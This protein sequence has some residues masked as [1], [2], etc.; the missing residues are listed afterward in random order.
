MTFKPC[1]PLLRCA[2]KASVVG[3][4]HPALHEA[5]LVVPAAALFH[6]GETEARPYGKVIL[7]GSKASPSRDSFLHQDKARGW[8]RPLPGKDRGSGHLGVPL[9]A[10]APRRLLT[11]VPG[12]GVR[13]WGHAPLKTMGTARP[14]PTDRREAAPVLSLAL[15]R[16]GSPADRRARRFL[17]TELTPEGGFPAN[18]YRCRARRGD[19]G[20]DTTGSSAPSL[21][22]PASP[23]RRW[24]FPH[25]APL[26]GGTSP[27][28][29]HLSG[30]REPALPCRAV[31][32]RSRAAGAS[33]A[34]PPA[35]W[36]RSPGQAGGLRHVTAALRAHLGALA[37]KGGGGG[38]A[39]RHCW[40]GGREAPRRDPRPVSRRLR[41]L[42]SRR[43]AGSSQAAA[44][45]AAPPPPPPSL[46]LS[47][48]VG[49][50]RAWRLGG[51]VAG[52]LTAARASRLRE[53]LAAVAAWRGAS[54]SRRVPNPAVPGEGKRA[55]PEL[56]LRAARRGS[57]GLGPRAGP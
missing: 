52:R 16:N 40:R 42:S 51:A 30:R 24:G 48:A 49:P 34:A 26:L 35:R 56:F 43:G 28:S 21:S 55:L 47:R 27:S 6:P 18:G 23:S 2:S 29:P 44:A 37:E 36:R 7:W 31:R 20:Q 39:G 8:G 41:P 22:T 19:N 45:S 4:A 9:T 15:W 38:E 17:L 46:S 3:S 12:G 5:G 1:P 54:A 10:R 25:P 57:A 32:A 13:P 14:L 11:P 50:L 53:N 33:A